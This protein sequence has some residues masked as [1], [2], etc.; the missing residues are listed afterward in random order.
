MALVTA[1]N[2]KDARGISGSSL[3]TPLGDV[4]TAAG[5]M[6]LRYLG[7]SV[8]EQAAISG[9]VAVSIGQGLVQLAEWPIATSPAPTCTEDGTAL[10]YG[11]DFDIPEPYGSRGLVRRIEGSSPATV[12]PWSSSSAGI[13]FGYTAGYAAASAPLV[14][15]QRAALYQALLIWSHDPR[16]GDSR[17]QTSGKTYPQGGTVTY[18]GESWSEMALGLLEPYRRLW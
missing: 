11:T 8:I 6:V 2:I 10:T 13:V 12:R 16:S 1:T 9:E 3:D 4:A 7:R 14:S 15:I 5:A 17:N 18:R